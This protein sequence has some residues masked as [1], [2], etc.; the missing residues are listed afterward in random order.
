MS[1]LPRRDNIVKA[2]L[3]GIVDAQQECLRWTNNA[4]WLSLAPEY[5]MNIFIGQHLSKLSPMPEIWFEIGIEDLAE[6]IGSKDKKAF[7]LGVQ[8]NNHKLEKIDIVLDNN[9]KS[10][11]II[12]V[13]NAI[14]DY[15]D[16]TKKDILRICN[17]LKY[18]NQLNYG[19]FACFA[20]IDK[21]IEI[22]NT[23][24]NSILE[25][26]RNEANDFNVDLQMV[27]ICPTDVDGWSC[28]AA[29]FVIS[30]K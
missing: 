30:R 9:G 2:I 28:A 16:G 3:E 14:S 22:E 10:E 20:N 7:C 8:R 27:N 5:M 13:K 23:L 26:I 12:E 18:G 21:K 15:G 6:S 4:A 29:C 24:K 17:A 1:E 25:N 11:V 19:I